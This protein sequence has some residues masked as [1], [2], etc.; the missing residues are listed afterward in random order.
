MYPSVTLVTRLGPLCCELSI[1]SQHGLGWSIANPFVT[2]APAVSVILVGVF[3]PWPWS[4]ARRCRSA[5]LV[6]VLPITH[7]PAATK[8]IVDERME[9][10]CGGPG[11]GPVANL[12]GTCEDA[13]HTGN[14]ASSHKSAASAKHIPILV[15]ALRHCLARYEGLV[16]HNP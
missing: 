16:V 7:L 5:Q 12:F 1:P 15:G 4:C 13:N 3:L 10:A 2:Q 8:A 9:E 11:E 14:H 6:G